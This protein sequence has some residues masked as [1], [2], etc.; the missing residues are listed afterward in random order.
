MRHPL[1]STG[2]LLASVPPAKQG[3]DGRDDAA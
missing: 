1:L 2:G 3:Q